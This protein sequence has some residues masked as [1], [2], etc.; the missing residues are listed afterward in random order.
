MKPY[1]KMSKEEL[2]QEKEA[3]E[4]QYKAFVKKD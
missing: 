3:L 2:L 1:Q 4:Q